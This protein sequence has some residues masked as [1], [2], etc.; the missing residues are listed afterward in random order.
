LT[1]VAAAALVAASAPHTARAD[2]LYIG[3]A[4]DNLVKRFDV[5]TGTLDAGFTTSGLLGPN[6]MVID[7][8]RLLVVNQNVNTK[9]AGEVLSYDAAS[10]GSPSPIVAATDKDAPFVPR[11][12]VLGPAG[13]DLFVGNFT[14][15]N[16]KSHGSLLRYDLDSGAL[17]SNDPV[18]GFKNHDFHPRGVVFGPDGLL[19]VASP[20]NLS[21]GLGGAVLRF[22]ADG[23]FVDA[24]VEDAGG[25]G[26]LNRPEGLV[27]D[28]DGNL[29]VSSFRAA[30]GDVDGVRIYDADGVLTGQ[31]DYWDGVTAP[32][33][34]AQAL[35]FG[36][37]GKLFVPMTNTGEVRAYDVTTGDYTPFID[38]GTTLINP[39]FMTFGQT[40]PSTLA[41]G[42][43]GAGLS[44]GAVAVPEPA[45][46]A[47][48][49]FACVGLF[50]CAGIATRR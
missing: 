21:T 20:I 32:R 48:A 24:F 14:T 45:T 39:L 25:F 28:P 37:D 3:D 41:Y 7:G 6:G 4:G 42:G 36:P 31:I 8:D 13:D 27:F 5:A 30:P 2:V 44:A 46:V 35:L 38:A 18:K 33:A 29:Y 10:G 47:L 12:I 23:S 19:Y 49:V 22:N 11:G 40:D 1:L 26:Q 9:L 50:G 17:L 15:A 34:F 16:G 43:M